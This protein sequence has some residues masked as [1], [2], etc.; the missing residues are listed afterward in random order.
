METHFS[1][2]AWKVPWM[3]EPG[4][5][6][7]VGLH[8]VRHTRVSNTHTHSLKSKFSLYLDSLP[9][10]KAFILIFIVESLNHV[11]PIEIP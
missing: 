3:K 1:I 2:L 4:E 7:S 9:G 5:L 8:R 6:Q 10:L 11:Q